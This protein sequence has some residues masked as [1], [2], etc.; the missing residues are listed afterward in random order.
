MADVVSS[1]IS[2][3]RIERVSPASPVPPASPAR[4]LTAARRSI[5]A[6]GVMARRSSIVAVASHL[7]EE[8][9][10]PRRRV[11]AIEGDLDPE[12]TRPKKPAS[13]APKRPVP[14]APASM[15]SPGNHP[16][17]PPPALP[18][19]PGPEALATNASAKASTKKPLNKKLAA[20]GFARYLASVHIVAGHLMNNQKYPQYLYSWRSSH[21]GF[22]WVPWSTHKTHKHPTLTD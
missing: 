5:V 16:L 8:Q 12:V 15:L 11:S 17:P 6:A 18:S 7:T 19:A 14:P 13:P 2:L 3:E 10:K 4:R 21:Y 20:F 1:P 9:P 22:T